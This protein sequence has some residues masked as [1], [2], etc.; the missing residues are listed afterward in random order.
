[1]EYCLAPSVGV[2][3]VHIC[4]CMTLI[5]EHEKYL[6]KSQEF[7]RVQWNDKQP[8][9]IWFNHDSIFLALVG[10]YIK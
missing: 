3:N 4:G 8:K 6:H 7:D 9:C 2:W 10:I 5:I 1:M